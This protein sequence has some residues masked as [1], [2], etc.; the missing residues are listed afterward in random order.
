MEKE[1]TTRGCKYCIISIT[2]LFGLSFLFPTVVMGSIPNITTT[3]IVQQNKVSIAGRVVDSNGDP[4]TNAT[5]REL[6]THNGTITDLNGDY[7]LSVTIGATLQFSSIGYKTLTYTVKKSG[8]VNCTLEEDASLLNEIVAIGYGKAKKGDL[9]AAVATVDNVDKLQ[10]RPVSNV[11]QMLQ[12]Q[13]PGVSVVANGGHPGSEPTITI[14][15]M[16]SPNG[17]TPLYVVDGVPGAPFNMSDVVSITVLKDAASA[18][19][20]GAYAGSAG[21]ILVTTKQATAGKPSVEYNG[22]FGFSTAQN[23]P[24]SLSWEDEMRVRAYSYQQ[25]GSTLPAGWNIIS[26]DPVYGKTNTDWIKQIFRTAAFNRHNI[27]ISGGN[28]EFSNRLSLEINNA[29]GTLV[30]TYNRQ[31]TARLNSMWKITKFLRI[32]EDL[33]WKDRKVHDVNTTSAESGVILAALMFP[34][35][36][37]P[38]EGNGYMG[39][40]PKAYAEYANIHGD[41]INPMRIL[42]AAY[43]NNHASTFTSTTF[44]DIVQPITGLN[45]TSR[46]TW[47]Q[48]NYMLRYW[49]PQ[50]T[51]I[52]KPNLTNELYYSNYREPQWD[53]ENTLTYDRI[54]GKHTMGLMASTTASQYSYRFNDATMRGFENEINSMMYF[55]NGT[56]VINPNDK[57]YKDRNVSYVARGAYSFA[58]RYFV[59]ASL[60]RDYASR[61]PKGKKYG[62]FPSVTAAWKLTSEP[63][64]KKNSIL[65]VLKLRASWGKIGNLG[66][67]GYG[68]GVAT[69]STRYPND[70]PDVGSQIGIDN[71]IMAGVYL[72]N[73]FNRNLTWETSEQTDFGVDAVL[74]NNHLHLSID[75]FN[76]NTRNLI[77]TQ[78]VNWPTTIGISA[79]LINDGEVNN[80]GVEISA[81]W[82]DKIGRNV[83]YYVGGNIATLRN[84]L[85]NIGAANPD[86]S[87]P[88]WTYERTYRYKDLT[89]YRSAE[90]KPLYSYYL[91]RTDGVF[92]TDE[93]AAAYVN[94]NGKRLQPKAKAGDLKFVDV[95]N[96][97]EIGEGDYEFRGNAMPKLTYAFS[98]GFSYKNFSFD[99][100]LQGS[101]GAKLFNAY[102]YTTLNEA[103]GSFNRSDKILQA[104][105]GPT[106]AVPRISMTDDNDNFGRISDWYL[107]S[108]SYLRMKNISISYSFTDLLRKIAFFNS[109]QSTLDL[110]LS[111]DNLFTITPY[112]GIDPEVGGV[113][114]DCG[115]YP[116]SRTVSLAVKIKF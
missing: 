34:R 102:K 4:I 104:L 107:E 68:Y 87:K 114:F 112:T 100:M 73:A 11:S 89:P 19:I 75:Y 56:Q 81:M 70:S 71:R 90:G 53:W 13:I 50:R 31:V 61:L 115:Q 113:G 32:R 14:R 93:E 84:R 76:K 60:R 82:K 9:S 69:L 17:E 55:A 49:R 26:K 79:P 62:D 98:A 35:N 99:F 3:G 6:G 85:T 97:G 101:Y 36:T 109:R 52:G 57:Y 23:L 1:R 58:D 106:Y 42:E 24:Q 30:N 37:F 25:A 54:F 20:Y 91:L 40:V 45:F 47:M 116:V 108:D 67:I 80:R 110:T 7:K 48:T 41:A 92:K 10:K 74:F 88:V 105:N 46:F 8:A 12:G 83:S 59:T 66:S 111:C 16:G 86:G 77:K 15:G 29:D 94:A 95:D 78:D 43:D 28:E 33:S 63:W 5:V 39:T 27:A 22:V 96:D 103:V 65:N 51:E 18:A 38:Y 2:A 72:A 44:L 64:F 21:V